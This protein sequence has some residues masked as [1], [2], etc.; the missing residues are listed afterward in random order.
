[1]R[2]RSK[3]V[4][5]ALFVAAFTAAARADETIPL[6]RSKVGQ[7]AHYKLT[8][9]MEL[10]WTVTKVDGKKITIKTVHSLKGKENPATFETVDLETKKA[11]AKKADAKTSEETLEIAGK[12][13]K[14]KVV[15]DGNIKTWSCEDDVPV[16]GLVKKEVS[17]KVTMELAGWGDEEEKKK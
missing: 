1:M 12:K 16:Y 8:N 9:D 14:C 10:K 17:G 11:P 13:L 15:E 4:S 7:W 6:A 2:S 3:L 5:A